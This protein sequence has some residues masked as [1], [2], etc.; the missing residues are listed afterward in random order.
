MGS[1]GVILLSIIFIFVILLLFAAAGSLKSLQKQLTEIKEKYKPYEDVKAAISEVLDKKDKAEA[2]LIDIEKEYKKYEYLIIEADIK[3]YDYYENEYNFSS[4]DEYKKKLDAIRNECRMLIR[5]NRAVN[6]NI[7]FTMNGSHSEG[8]KVI[9]DVVKLLL[10]TLNNEVENILVK[11]RFDNL[12][13]MLDRLDKTMISINKI[14]SRFNCYITN[15]YIDLK[16]EEIKLVHEYQQKLQEE[17]DEIRR[18]KEEIRE[19]ERAKKEAEQARKKAEQEENK[20]QEM[21][22][23]AKAEAEIAVGEKQAEML[24]RIAEL[25]ARVEAAKHLKEKA[26]SMAQLTKAGFVYVISNIGSFGEDVF[27]IGMT[28]RLEPLDRVR[29]LGDASVPFYFDVH[30]LIPSDDAPALEREI[31]Q[32]FRN[33]RLNMVS[34]RREFFRINMSELETFLLNKNIDIEFNREAI[35]EEFRESQKIIS[36]LL[37]DINDKQLN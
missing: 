30:A 3:E 36:E 22:D 8:S 37:M 14:S 2:Q 16:K 1:V 21:L 34:E 20:Y 31:Q 29:E 17:K 24:N 32:H 13:K 23:K 7:N 27:K 4:S 35:A 33:K 28:R 12:Y 6:T 19:E 5:E 15:N 25:E 18:I 26:I 10:L 9:K 11:V